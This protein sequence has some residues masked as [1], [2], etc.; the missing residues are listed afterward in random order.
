MSGAVKPPQ[1]LLDSIAGVIRLEL[2]RVLVP[3]DAPL[4][5]PDTERW[6]LVAVVSKR[7]RRDDLPSVEGRHFGIGV[8]GALWDAAQ[9]TLDPVAL[10]MRVVDAGFPSVSPDIADMIDYDGPLPSLVDLAYMCTQVRDYWARR[11]LHRELVA[12]ARLLAAEG[13]DCEG[14]FDRLRPIAREVRS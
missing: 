9:D 10:H 4:V 7:V 11:L 1:G 5:L 2:D 6:L 14:V 8:W 12:C 13:V 3:T